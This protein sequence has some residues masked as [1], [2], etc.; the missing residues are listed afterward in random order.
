MAAAKGNNYA[1]E[2]TVENALPRFKD[3]L[4]YAEENENCLCLQD[5]IKETLIPIS[6][7]KYLV[8]N[9]KV[10]ALIKE[11]IMAA[12]IRRINRNALNGTFKETSS[13]FRM[14]QLGERDEQTVHN[15]NTQ[16]EPIIIKW[17]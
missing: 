6:T 9:Q 14:K 4:K 15:V 7:F 1:S 12:I 17:K 16:N 8:E 3:A 10:L 5:A 11:D 2:W 13:I